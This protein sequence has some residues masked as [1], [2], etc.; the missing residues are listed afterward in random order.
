MGYFAYRNRGRRLG[1]EGLPCGRSLRSS[2]VAGGVS[3]GDRYLG[4]G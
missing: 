2:S 4:L 1:A 3:G